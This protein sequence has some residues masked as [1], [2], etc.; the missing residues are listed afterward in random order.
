MQGLNDP[1]IALRDIHLPPGP[2]WWPLA[3]GGWLV[4]LVVVFGGTYLLYCIIRR[5][6]R[7]TAL[8]RMALSTIK[9]LRQRAAH[10]E[11]QQALVAEL[12]LLLRTVAIKTFPRQTVAGLIGQAWLDF[13]DSSGTCTDFNFGPGQS[14]LSAPYHRSEQRVDLF[15]L[16]DVVERW[17]AKIA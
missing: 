9:R 8:R 6:R 11:P 13:L 15:R 1:L 4:L 17:I 12:S 16:F 7:R 10:G 3:P 5:W 2:P 14:L